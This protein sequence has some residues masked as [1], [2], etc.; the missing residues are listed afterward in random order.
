LSL[1]PIGIEFSG[2]VKKIPSL[3]PIRSRVAMSCVPSFGWAVVEWTVDVDP[4]VMEGQG[5]EIFSVGTIVSVSSYM[6]YR[7]DGLFPPRLGFVC[8][9]LLDWQ[10]C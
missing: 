1:I 10:I 8:S 6:E 5:L 2:L 9:D 7:E 3:C 4:L